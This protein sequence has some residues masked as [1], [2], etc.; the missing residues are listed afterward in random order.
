MRQ[1]DGPFEQRINLQP[2]L[3]AVV[4]AEKGALGKFDHRVEDFRL[5]ARIAQMEQQVR[6]ER[7]LLIGLLGLEQDAEV[8]ERLDEV[9]GYDRREISVRD[10]WWAVR[11]SMSRTGSMISLRFRNEGHMGGLYRAHSGV[12]HFRQRALSDTALVSR[13]ACRS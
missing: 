2:G 6:E 11:L 5:V 13:A 12:P 8:L 7:E 4:E 3:V 9:A 1:R 10:H